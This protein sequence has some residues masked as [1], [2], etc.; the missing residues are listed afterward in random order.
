MAFSGSRLAARRLA[1]GLTQERLGQLMRVE[2][3]RISEWERGVMAPRPNLM[4]ELAAALGLDALEFLTVDPGAP[5]LEDMRLAAGL[6]MREV[7]G[8][9]G[10]SLRRYRGMEIGATRR[11]PADGLVEE[12]ARVFAV[13][14]VMV[15]RAVGS[16]RP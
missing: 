5:S 3:T 1:V 15:L 16:A 7:A 11:D 4:P 6:T 8:E 9:L 12:L 14:A 13:P 2:Q 10:I